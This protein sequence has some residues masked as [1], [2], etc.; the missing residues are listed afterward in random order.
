MEIK[1]IKNGTFNDNISSLTDYYKYN[2]DFSNDPV[3]VNVHLY[4]IFKNRIENYKL[5]KKFNDIKEKLKNYERIKSDK[6][7]AYKEKLIYLMNAYKKIMK[8]ADEDDFYCNDLIYSIQFSYYEHYF[9]SGIKE[10]YKRL[11]KAIFEEK[12]KDY[13]NKEKIIILINDLVQQLIS[14][15][16]I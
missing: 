16:I 14:S 8:D 11:T 7:K 13:L 5:E 12:I 9:K 6:L 10:L 1:K 15:F 4:I 2:N 3:S